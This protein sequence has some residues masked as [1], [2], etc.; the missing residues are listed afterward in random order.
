[1]HVTPGTIVVLI[2]SVTLLAAIAAA[3]T[4]VVA[5]LWSV[6]QIQ[7]LGQMRSK[8]AELSAMVDNLEAQ[9]IQLRTKKA[10]RRSQESRA[11]KE[12]E[13]PDDPYLA[14]LSPEDRALFGG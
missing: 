1:M 12:A 5:L 13:E 10:N 11:E 9:V 6:K 7:P 4:L 14:G 2:A 8:V 3:S